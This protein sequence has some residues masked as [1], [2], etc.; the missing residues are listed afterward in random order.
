[1]QAPKLVIDARG[2]VY[3]FSRMAV[4]ID[5]G[6]GTAIAS[7]VAV[8]ELPNRFVYPMHVMLY[9]TRYCC[10]THLEQ[11]IDRFSLLDLQQI[12]QDRRSPDL[13][14]NLH[15]YLIMSPGGI[16]PSYLARTICNNN[17]GGTCFLGWARS[18]AVHGGSCQN[19]S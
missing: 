9:S 19:F 12:F 6:G 1:M 7:I 18:T 2:G 17:S 14:K 10:S 16:Q 13:R 15:T 4:V 3:S 5:G 11:S 8:E